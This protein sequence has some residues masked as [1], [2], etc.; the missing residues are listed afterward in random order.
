MDSLSYLLNPNKGKDAYVEFSTRSMMSSALVGEEMC[1]EDLLHWDNID[2]V[3]LSSGVKCKK[4]G[5]EGDVVDP[6][7]VL[8]PN[9]GV[10][11]KNIC[12][13][14]VLITGSSFRIIFVSL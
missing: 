3:T 12:S 7:V 2:W 11:G 13:T 5:I 10:V 4:F 8:T 1:G 9:S 14:L 6:G